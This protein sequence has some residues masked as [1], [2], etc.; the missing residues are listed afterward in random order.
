[1]AQNLAKLVVQLEMETARYSKELDKAKNQLAGFSKST[2][3][4]VSKIAKAAGAAALAAAVGFAALAKN[5]IDAADD[6]N[7]MA[8]AT[9]VSVESLSQLQYAAKLSGTN[10]D[11]LANGLRKL[12]TAAFDAAKGVKGPVES[13]EQLGIKVTDTNGKL[14]STEELLLETADVFAQYEDGAAKAAIAQDLF[15][16][17]GT[18]LI[19]F[20]NQG[21]AGIEGLKNEAAALSLTISGQTA[22]AAD[23][24]NDSLT[25]LKSSVTGL[26][27]QATTALLPTLQA[28]TAQ[29]SDTVT[30]SG[31]MS[32]FSEQIAAG[33][34]I[35]VD[36]GYSVYKTFD[37]IGGA[38]GALAA[39]AVAVASGEFKRAA[40]IIRMANAD[41]VASE[42]ESNEFIRKLWADTGASIVATAKETDEE[43]KKTFT[44]GGGKG[45]SKVEE[46]TVVNASKIDVTPYQKF[47]EE[48]NALTMTQ[49]ERQV[50]AYHEQREALTALF[51]DG[52]ISAEQF[53]DRSAAALDE[54]LPEFEVTAKKI[55]EVTVKQ[56]DMLTEFQKQAAANTQDILAGTF[57]EL[58]T[59][60]DLSAKK[61]LQT[62]GQMIVKLIA[63]AAAA[64]LAGRL[65]GAA[66]GGTGG[67][68]IGALAGA[69][70]GGKAAGGP[71]S[72]NSAYMVGERG[73][74]MFVPNSAGKI[75]PNNKL[76]GGSTSISNHFTVQTEQPVT[77]RTEEQL[78][79][80][81]SRGV[82][83][84]NRRNN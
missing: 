33:F 84:A 34:K 15:G 79:A 72:P 22:A 11:G 78:A 29:L 10:L 51:E 13:F 45:A 67:G 26:A 55:A 63:Q 44:F 7:D 37:N 2:N 81:A 77:R 19:P 70:G 43:V 24:F 56:T 12:N 27:N 6:L 38:L 48:L 47:T 23:E 39:A 75:V 68:W 52:A 35:V 9:G 3:D 82:A 16:K 20:L 66:G 64:D 65:F 73:P 71:V 60:G 17:S 59:S 74:E 28:I 53:A 1:M 57:E 46:V 30:Q 36:I 25:R 80:A 32:K 49:T 50:A 41:Q 31:A 69:F 14:K 54:L 21:R 76:G 42:K 83:R 58:A 61:I 18:A 62:F 5:S 8:K 40:N 4:S